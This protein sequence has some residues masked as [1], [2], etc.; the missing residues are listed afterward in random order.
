MTMKDNTKTNKNKQKTAVI[1]HEIEIKRELQHFFCCTF[2]S[3][4]INYGINNDHS[5]TYCIIE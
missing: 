3:N 5:L 1:K 2:H 4:C